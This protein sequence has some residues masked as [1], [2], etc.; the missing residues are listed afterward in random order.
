VPDYGY[1]GRR[2][3]PA[4]QPS[5]PAPNLPAL[6]VTASRSGCWFD[7]FFRSDLRQRSFQVGDR[8]I[9]FRPFPDAKGSDYPKISSA[10]G[11]LSG[12]L[13]FLPSCASL[14]QLYNE[15]F[16]GSCATKEFR[17]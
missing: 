5:L 7:L 6:P 8:V 14:I 2:S 3:D 16:D 15:L 4:F 17:K 10:F 9:V 11:Q 12:T 1:Y 13:Q